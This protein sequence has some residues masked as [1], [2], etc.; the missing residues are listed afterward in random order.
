MKFKKGIILFV[1]FT[2]ISVSAIYLLLFSSRLERFYFDF[3]HN[4]NDVDTEAKIHEILSKFE[5][6][7]FAKL[8]KSFVVNGKYNLEKY[9]MLYQDK[10]FYKLKRK[11]A[12]Q[13]IVG[14]WRIDDFVSKD[15][16]P[17][18]TY[19]FD[20]KDIYWLTDE[21]ILVAFLKLKHDFEKNSLDWDEIRLSSSHRSPNRNKKVGG[22]PQSRHICGDAI[23]L[24]VGDI[25]RNNITNQ[26]DKLKVLELCETIIADKGGIGLYPGTYRVHIDMR[27]HYARW[28][29]YKPDK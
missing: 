18:F 23:D 28:N 26:K 11:Q 6:V 25:D 27:G 29:D 13:K 22:A 12:L 7:P 16:K 5:K 24:D 19:F 9:K 10:Y 21:K 17:L 4:N 1:V 3:T 14:K 20:N 8:P 15:E 2:F